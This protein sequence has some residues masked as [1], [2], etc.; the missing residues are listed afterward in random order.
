M[1]A[2]DRFAEPLSWDDRIWRATLELNL[3]AP[4]QLL[5]GLRNAWEADAGIVLLGS[6]SAEDGCFARLPNGDHIGSAAYA[7]SKSALLGLMRTVLRQGWTQRV[8][9]LH[10]GGSDTN[11]SRRLRS[12][13]PSDQQSDQMTP[14]EVAEVVLFLMRSTAMNGAAIRADRGLRAGEERSKEASS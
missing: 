7:A 4:A 2:G 12:A 13:L 9:I 5:I 1:S 3:I 8:N 11:L 14:G 10:A 6:N